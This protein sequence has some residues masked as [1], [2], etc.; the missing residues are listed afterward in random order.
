[1]RRYRRWTVEEKRQ[2]VER[3]SSCRHAKLAAEIGI[4]QRQLYSW[5]KD[6]KKLEQGPAE[7]RGGSR[8]Q[9]LERENEQLK[10]ALAKK[11]KKVVEAD[12]LQ[13]VLRRIEARRQPSSGSGET[14][15]TSRSK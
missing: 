14:A 13:G 15:S 2:A 8:E 3:M 4:P 5:R 11:V 9:R 12:F 6:L 10:Q 1:M 7:V